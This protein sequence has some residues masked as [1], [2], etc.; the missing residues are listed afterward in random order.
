MGV[1]ELGVSNRKHISFRANLGDDGTDGMTAGELW[2]WMRRRKTG[3]NGECTGEVMM[4]NGA[5][6]DG[7]VRITGGGRL[8]SELGEISWGRHDAVSYA[9]WC[10]PAK[11]EGIG[12][13]SGI[14]AGAML[15]RVGGAGSAELELSKRVGVG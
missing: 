12:A 14:Q 9:M 4:R 5:K 7:F 10:R 1:D 3:E 13:D 8:E 11:Q 6:L 2:E 15:N